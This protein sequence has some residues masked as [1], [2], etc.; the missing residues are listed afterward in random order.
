MAGLGGAGLS[1]LLSHL[2]P[3]NLHLLRLPNTLSKSGAADVVVPE[4]AP[5]GWSLSSFQA[6]PF[7]G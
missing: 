2:T 3:Q 5:V 6:L 4:Q 7:L 1:W